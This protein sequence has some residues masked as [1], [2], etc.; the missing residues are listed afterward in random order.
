MGRIDIICSYIDKC[1]SFADVGCD[2]GFCTERTLAEGKCQSAVITD[3]SA[4]CLAKAEKLLAR[5]VDSGVCRSVC[6]D[7]LSGVDDGVEQVLIAGMGGEEIIKILSRGFIPQKF[8][9]QPMNHAPKVRKFLID[10]GCK[11]TADDLFR[12][13][14]FYFIIKGER[15]GGEENYSEEQLYFGRDSLK[16]SVLKEYAK[17]ELE[18]KERYLQD[19]ERAGA[20]K[21]SCMKL[22]KEITFLKGVVYDR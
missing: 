19:C 5:Y 9:L 14:K 1:K 15:S 3:I 20:D 16:N 7:G 18:K 17:T 21:Q 10:S 8:I 22:K 6:C 2:H 13:D 4:K 12:D 11:I